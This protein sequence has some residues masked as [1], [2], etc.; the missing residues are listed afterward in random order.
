LAAFAI[1]SS[2]MAATFVAN[3]RR[4]L[5]AQRERASAALELESCRADHL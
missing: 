3:S 4:Y 5:R 1:I 2:V